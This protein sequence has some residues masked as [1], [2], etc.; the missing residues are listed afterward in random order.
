MSTIAFDEPDLAEA[1]CLVE[2]ARKLPPQLRETIAAQ[3]LASLD[4]PED[5]DESLAAW[6]AELQRRV[7][8]I[9]DGTMPTYSVEET[10]AYVRQV[11]GKAR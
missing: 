5:A 7:D 9:R 4:A 10:M 11:L 6:H 8:G 2:R 1:Q 3:L